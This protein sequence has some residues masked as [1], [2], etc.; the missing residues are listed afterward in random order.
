MQLFVP[1]H[2]QQVCFWLPDDAVCTK[3]TVQLIKKSHTFPFFSKA[4]LLQEA[5]FFIIIFT[6]GNG[7]LKRLASCLKCMELA[8][9][10]LLGHFGSVYLLQV[11]K[12]DN[13]KCCCLT[14]PLF[15]IISSLSEKQKE[16]FLEQLKIYF[17]QDQN[18][19]GRVEC[20]RFSKWLFYFIAIW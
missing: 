5:T 11:S 7:V 12:N 6:Y 1:K 3:N 13:G 20:L 15:E 8:F 17:L 4:K 2:Q 16:F 14:L 18:K 19:L 10:V 9:W